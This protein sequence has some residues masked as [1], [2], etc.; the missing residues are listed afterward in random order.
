MMDDRQPVTY[1][2]QKLIT[3]YVCVLFIFLYY[4]CYFIYMLETYLF[5][6]MIVLFS[7]YILLCYKCCLFDFSLP[8]DQVVGRIANLFATTAQKK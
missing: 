7:S 4:C 3:N 8:V 5:L 1:N 6:F 2:G